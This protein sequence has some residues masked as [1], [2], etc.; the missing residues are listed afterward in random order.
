MKK[1][2]LTTAWAVYGGGSTLYHLY[3]SWAVL[4]RMCTD[5]FKNT[6]ICYFKVLFTG[7][8]AFIV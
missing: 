7:L 3:T 8:Y 4:A 2:K 1:G 5:T 6:S